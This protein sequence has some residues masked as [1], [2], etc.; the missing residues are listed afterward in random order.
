MLSAFQLHAYDLPIQVDCKN[1]VCDCSRV[2]KN[3][4]DIKQ[5]VSSIDKGFLTDSV[6]IACAY[7]QIAIQFYSTH[8][9]I[10]SS[11]KFNEKAEEIRAKKNDGLLWRTYLN[12]GV[13]YYD[14][15]EHNK[16][17]T[18]LEKALLTEGVKEESD[19][20]KIYRLLA[21][22]YMENGDFETASSFARKSISINSTQSKINVAK[23]TL[24]A[25]LINFKDSVNLTEAIKYAKDVLKSSQAIEDDE[26]I[27]IAL[28]NLANANKVLGNYKNAITYYQQAFDATD[29]TDAENKAILLNNMAAISQDQR[30]YKTSIDQ[31]NESLSIYKAYLQSN[32]HYDYSAN[33]EN[34]ADNYLALNEI[35]SALFYYQK[36]LINFTNNFR[37]EDIF[38]NP[39]TKNQDL[40]IYSNLDLIRVLHLKATAAFKYYQQNKEEKYLIL[41]NQT[42]QTAF[43][44]HNK[45][46]K[47]IST[48]NSRLFQTKNT[49][50]YIENALK[51][52][53]T[54]QKD[55]HD[56]GESAFRFMEKNKATVLLQSMNE[57][58]ALQFA[59]LPDSLLEHEK[60]LKI[61]LTFHEKQLNEA[62]QYQ[63]TIEIER[64]DKTLFEEKQ[65]YNQLISDL[66]NNYPNYFR[67]KYQ[68]NQT[69]LKNV[70]QLFKTKKPIEWN[71]TIKIFQN[72]ITLSDPKA[73]ANPYTKKLYNQYVNTAQTLYQWLLKKPLQNLENKPHLKI[74]PDAELNYI[75][76][77][78]LL[79]GTNETSS[80][81]YK[82][83]PYLLK[84]RTISYHYS[85]TLF[86][87]QAVKSNI[88][89]DYYYGGY[90]AQYDDT[91][92][93]NLDLPEVRQLTGEMASFFNGKA[94]LEDEATKEQ[95]LKDANSYQVLHLS[96][97]GKLDD[98]YPLNSHLVFTKTTDEFVEDQFQL[99]AADL[100]NHQLNTNL[101]V[102]SACQTGTGELQKGEGVM[103]LSRAFTYAGCPSLVMSLWSI[104]EKS[105][106]QVLRNF[107]KKIKK[108]K[109]KDVALRQAKLTYLENASPAAAHP[110]Y[111]AGLVLSGSAEAMYFET[112]SNILKWV[113]MVAIFLT[114]FWL[115]YKKISQ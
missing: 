104:P 63:D 2:A 27:K 71:N 43:N 76:F 6:L 55:G 103:S 50:S 112:H 57:A 14:L 7:H 5:I 91:D 100:Y 95:F 111:W 39:N 41:A 92:S 32:Y 74:I 18:Y 45:L 17:K 98:Q 15:Y 4:F 40:F 113:L 38:T 65:Q 94:Y 59:N 16:A 9:N 28:N 72:A 37:N 107:F 114:L 109:S 66:E 52:V 42:Y 78:L 8:Y 79:S 88:K 73:K 101:A 102:L 23:N 22:C 69:K 96:M 67:L 87:E 21:E 10:L 61:A 64:L 115:A 58:D 51:I 12:T 80:I 68:Q 31:L 97:H 86:T 77:D 110:V 13:N 54:L 24:A 3:S 70:T 89:K 99:Y 49:V 11:I 48:E 29:I 82:T 108:G 1:N 75:P 26:N 44:F 83:L 33:Y 30:K 35:D 93:V 81:N 90:A 84:E 46:Q 20:V 34:L 60:D 19:S 85:A 25:I 36:A 56:I 53:Y 62:I 106:V 47:D 105:S